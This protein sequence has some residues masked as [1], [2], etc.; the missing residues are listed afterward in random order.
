MAKEKMLYVWRQS[1]E[2]TQQSQMIGS[3]ATLSNNSTAQHADHSCSRDLQGLTANFITPPF[4]AHRNAAYKAHHFLAFKH[5]A[6]GLLHLHSCW[7]PQSDPVLT[8]SGVN[9]FIHS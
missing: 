6:S 1:M 5:S 9:V 7:R 4:P 2:L 3:K 8:H